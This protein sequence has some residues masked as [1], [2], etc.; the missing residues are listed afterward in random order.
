MA[1]S[2]AGSFLCARAQIPFTASDFSLTIQPE[3][4]SV[5]PGQLIIFDGILDNLSSQS[6]IFGG[7]ISLW[8]FSFSPEI[9]GDNLFSSPY[10]SSISF[11]F[12][13]NQTIVPGGNL[14]FQFMTVGTLP[15]IP[16][17]S[18]VT[19]G[20]GNFLFQNI[21]R[22]TSDPLV[23]FYIPMSLAS[24]VVAVPEPGT[25]LLAGLSLVVIWFRCKA[26]ETTH[27]KNA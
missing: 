13:F 25:L 1:F 12:S 17:G 2:L 4:S 20:D 21:P 9:N 3:H 5:Q 22:N 15:S 10:I 26:S 16:V 8:G 7:N 11:P 27:A 18:V 24:V 14:Q 23:D 19:S 6:A